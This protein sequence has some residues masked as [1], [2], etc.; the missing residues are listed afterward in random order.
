MLVFAAKGHRSFL[1]LLTS[2]LFGVD[3]E[4]FCGGGF[5]LPYLCSKN[6]WCNRRLFPSIVFLQDVYFYSKTFYRF[7]YEELCNRCWFTLLY[8]HTELHN[9]FDVFNSWSS[10]NIFLFIT[11]RKRKHD[12]KIH[13]NLYYLLSLQSY[14]C[15]FIILAFFHNFSF[16]Y[17]NFI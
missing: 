2:F 6:M 14:P 16:L 13:K 15:F 8:L 5:L 12:I 17:L 3:N 11:W 7:Y 4:P 1:L 10:K 9:M